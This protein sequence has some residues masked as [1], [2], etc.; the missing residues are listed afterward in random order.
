MSQITSGNASIDAQL[1]TVLRGGISF[2]L[3]SLPF[4]LRLEFVGAVQCVPVEGKVRFTG[5]ARL[6]PPFAL[7]AAVALTIA[8]DG[9]YELRFPCPDLR[10]MLDLH[11]RA[12]L[13]ASSRTIY[14]ALVRPYLTL[15]A[16]CTVILSSDVGE[17]PQLGTIVAGCNFY[18]VARLGD[19]PPLNEVCKAFPAAGIDGRTLVLHLG[20]AA[21]PAFQF[22]VEGEL[23]L[24]AE[25]GTPAVVLETIGLRVDQDSATLTASANCRFTVVVGG[26]RLACVGGIGLDSTG[27][28]MIYGSLDAEDG[29]WEAPFGAKG[30]AVTGLGVQAMVSKSPPYLGLGV[31]GGVRIGGEALDADLAVLFDASDPTRSI[32]DV[33]S[34]SG[35]DFAE[36]MGAMVDRR[37]LPADL[38]RV[39]LDR[40]RLTI[41][42]QGGTIAGK[43]YAPG[44]AVG[45]NLLLWGFEA[46]VD[47]QFN[48]A[49]GGHLHAT[50]SPL[51]LPASGVLVDVH[52]A[53]SGGPSVRIDCTTAR[54]AA[55]VDVALELVGLYDQSAVV[56]LDADRLHVALARTDLGVYRGGSFELTHKRA[57]IACEA[58]FDADLKLNLGRVPIRLQLGVGAAIT[59]SADVRTFEQIVDFRFDA[60][61]QRLTL[62]QR[63][64]LRFTDVASL[65]TYFVHCDKAIARLIGDN[66]ASATAAAIAWLRGYVPDAAQVG[67][68]L[69]D[70]GATCGAA[71]AALQAAF[72]L[73]AKACASVLAG[74]AYTPTQIAGA[75]KDVYKLGEEA[76]G[77]LLDGI[78]MSA[79]AV[80]GAM[81]GAFDWSAKETAKFLDSSLKVGD[82]AAKKALEAA[83]YSSSQIKGAMNSAYDWTEDQWD[84]F[85]DLF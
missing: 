31:R 84:S 7:E 37:C 45:G 3:F 48:Y 53:G 18:S 26:E 23:V 20:C 29:L 68:V 32:L 62:R 82:K 42:P 2:S 57:R 58:S 71:T 52:G 61:G 81:R 78:G 36:L 72:D 19:I 76:V 39:R 33:S 22:M 67:M 25:L 13:P 10:T 6:G 60:C 79:S 74:A 73:G 75:L 54:Q 1:S 21:T 55:D 77:V 51:K 5:Q 30:L 50:M 85:T 56:Q 8:A 35:I 65:A 24:A 49:D 9:G 44:F 46:A 40:L 41:S 63:A 17:D 4:E 27:R 80:A 59:A 66:L 43:E 47:G 34:R 64:E 70:V 15:L 28:A 11:V 38:V 69:H 16:G 12:R 14:D 83:G